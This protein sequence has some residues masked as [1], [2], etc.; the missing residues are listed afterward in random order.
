MTIGIPKHL[1]EDSKNIY[2]NWKYLENSFYVDLSRSFTQE[3]LGDICI[4]SVKYQKHIYIFHL[5]LANL[6][7]HPGYILVPI[8]KQRTKRSKESKYTNRNNLSR[9]YL[10][11]IIN[12]LAENDFISKKRHYYN[13]EDLNRA[14]FTSIKA[15]DK[16]YSIFDKCNSWFEK[17]LD[18]GI[19]SSISLRDQNKKELPIDYKS[20]TIKNR[21]R[22]MN[23]YCHLL[24]KN[25]L[26][27]KFRHFN[28]IHFKTVFNENINK[29]GR[30]Y[31]NIYHL[32][33]EERESFTFNN[34]KTVEKDFVSLHIVLL[35]NRIGK[36]ILCKDVYDIK[37]YP[38]NKTK[39][40][41]LILINS[42]NEHQAISSYSQKIFEKTNWG[43]IVNKSLFG[44]KIREEAKILISKI[45]EKHYLIKD[46]F[47]SNESLTLMKED[48]DLLFECL[49]LLNNRNIP[50]FPV[51]DSIIVPKRNE[52]DLDEIMNKVINEKIQISTSFKL[53]A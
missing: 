52:S 51:H 10:R 41:L 12:Y 11:E 47:C 19:T 44:K 15:T 3:Y 17:N 18:E 7:N 29:G 8:S 13:P 27:S 46:F 32:T 33:K 45:K 28:S 53:V 36:D 6:F 16:L 31:N 22:I 40:A 14:R 34:E 26:R 21:R 37:G 42:K 43:N 23:S 9:T 48:S 49:N 2:L 20:E 24:S 30:L 50:S 5:I 38:R 25:K 39:L 35:Y 1:K 4:H